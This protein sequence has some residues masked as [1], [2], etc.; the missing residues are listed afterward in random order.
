MGNRECQ[1]IHIKQI[2]W[3]GNKNK[4]LK[5]ALLIH[6][7]LFYAQGVKNAVPINLQHNVHYGA[8]GREAQASIMAQ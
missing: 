5:K 4:W 7:N 8:A 6:F 1:G 2:M 3:V